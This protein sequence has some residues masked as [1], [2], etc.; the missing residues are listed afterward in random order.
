MFEYKVKITRVIDGDTVDGMIDL[1][2]SVH[3]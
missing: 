2:F 3:R 1:G